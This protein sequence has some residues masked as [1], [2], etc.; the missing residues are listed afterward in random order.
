M[1][2]HDHLLA[3]IEAGVVIRDPIN[4]RG[5]YDLAMAVGAKPGNFTAPP[6]SRA[7]AHIVNQVSDTVVIDW[8]KA[9]KPAV[10]DDFMQRIITTAPTLPAEPVEPMTGPMRTDPATD[11]VPAPQQAAVH[12]PLTT[13]NKAAHNAAEVMVSAMQNAMAAMA[14]AS[15]NEE[16]V[17]EI[18]QSAIAEAVK[19]IEAPKQYIIV[20]DKAE[21]VLPKG[22]YVRP[23]TQTVLDFLAAG[24]NP[25]LVGPAGSGKTTL[26]KQVAAMLGKKYS[27]NSCSAGMSESAL[28]GW[29]LP[30]GTNGSFIHVPAPFVTAYEDDDDQGTLHNLDELDAADANTIVYCNEALGANPGDGFT[31][32]IRHERPFVRRSEKFFCGA[33]AN[34]YGTAG[35]RLYVGRGQLDGASL[36]RFW[37]IDVGYDATLEER[38]V[39]AGLLEWAR[40][41]RQQIQSC[42][43]RR[44]V[45]TRQLIQGSRLIANGMSLATVKRHFTNGWS[46]DDLAKIA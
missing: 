11:P 13:P 44:I 9:N 35:D 31:L 4:K 27:S 23:E 33:T 41:T 16:R 1:N 46:E 14:A 15:I 32:P 7:V 10:Y 42:K 25:L 34:T 45:S 17:V 18:V 6:K 36:N 22:D 21:I 26:L 43:L 20:R 28:V 40:R 30:V 38:M 12:E 19:D 5:L 2:S 8:L 24:I 29:L 39:H 37:T 3:A